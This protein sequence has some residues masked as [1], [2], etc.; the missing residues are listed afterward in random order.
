[1]RYLMID[2]DARAAA[3]PHAT[4]GRRR[5]TLAATFRHFASLSFRA[6]ATFIVSRRLS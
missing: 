5:D 3:E 2:A 4:P 6:F 1:M